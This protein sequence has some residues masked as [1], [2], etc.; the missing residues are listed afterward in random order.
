MEDYAAC[1][2]VNVH[3]ALKVGGIGFVSALACATTYIRDVAGAADVSK[4]S[5]RFPDQRCHK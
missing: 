1:S 2:A 5:W 3:S 4:A